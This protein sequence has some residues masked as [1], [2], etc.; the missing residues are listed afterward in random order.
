MGKNANR[1]FSRKRRAQG[2]QAQEGEQFQVVPEALGLHDQCE[3][4]LQGAAQAELVL[5]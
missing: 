2:L 4:L 1:L 5:Y 3:Q